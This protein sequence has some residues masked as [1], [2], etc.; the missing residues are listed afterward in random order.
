MIII[1]ANRLQLQRPIIKFRAQHHQN[2][3]VA[4]NTITL[5]GYVPQFHYFGQEDADIDLLITKI[6]DVDDKIFITAKI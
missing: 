3:I 5:G 2:K 4:L 6:N 1:I